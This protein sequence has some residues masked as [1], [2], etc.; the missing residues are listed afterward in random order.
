MGGGRMSDSIAANQIAVQALLAGILSAA[1]MPLGSL[2]AFVWHPRNRTVAFMMAFGGGALLAALAIDLV[3]SATEKGH[4]LEL[5]I[6]AIAGNLLY[7]SVNRIINNS[8]GFL[9][10]PSTTLIHLTQQEK[11]RI[12]QRISRLKHIDLFTDLEPIFRQQLAK[13]LLRSRCPKDTILYRQGDPS[14]SL[15]FVDR[16][17]VCLQNHQTNSNSEVHLSA[18]EMFGTL[19]FLTGCPHRRTAITLTDSKLDI[20][21]RSDFESLLQV[22]LNLKQST[23]AILQSKNVTDYL[24]EYHGLSLAEIDRWV[25]LAAKKLHLEGVIPPVIETECYP[26]KFLDL[27]LKIRRF[28][29][30]QHLYQEDLEEISVRLLYQN[31]RDG[32]IFFQP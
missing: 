13:Y 27:A 7:T 20:L 14:E 19:A 28:P 25:E 8:G 26:K 30:F 1:S 12:G 31:Y 17:E 5:V 11:H 10:K 6:G 32:H 16:G 3:G 4:L 24:Y 2:T 18:N 15:Y 21:P 29:I 22:S 9:R 23:A